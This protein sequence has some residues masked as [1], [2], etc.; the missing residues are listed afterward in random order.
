MSTEMTP[1]QKN[2]PV[3]QSY[4]IEGLRIR[5][6]ELHRSKSLRKISLEF[7]DGE[8]SHGTIDRIIKGHEPKKLSIRKKLGLPEIIEVRVYRNGKGRFS[9][10]D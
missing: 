5:L 2:M 6:T 1:T 3:Q 9:K 7:Y 4:S 8:V 10:G